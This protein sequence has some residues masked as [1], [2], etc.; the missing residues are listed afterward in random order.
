MS[1]LSRDL[2]IKEALNHP[3]HGRVYNCNY[4]QILGCHNNWLII[5]IFDY[6]TYEEQYKHI[7]QTIL[8]DNVMNIY[9]IILEGNFGDIDADDSTCHG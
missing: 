5:Y 1:S 8:D 9:L 7:N 4:S 3:R 2:K 6:G